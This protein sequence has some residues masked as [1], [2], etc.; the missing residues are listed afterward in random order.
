[1]DVCTANLV[2]KWHELYEET[3]ARSRALIFEAAAQKGM[4]DVQG[5]E[6]GVEVGVV[7]G[8][9]GTQWKEAVGWRGGVRV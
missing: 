1:M 4:G 7:G 5:N 8:A 9:K 6:E 2:F 3:A